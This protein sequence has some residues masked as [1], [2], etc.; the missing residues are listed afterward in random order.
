MISVGKKV[1]S[2]RFEKIKHIS[3]GGYGDVSIFFDRV[4]KNMVVIK[5]I[6]KNPSSPKMT[7]KAV[8]SEVGILSRLQNSCEESFLCYLD[9]LEDE[10]FYYILTEYLGA[11]IWIYLI[12]LIS[13]IQLISKKSLKLLRILKEDFCTCHKLG[14]VHRDI[15]PENIMVN[16]QSG[17]IKYI[18]FGA[19]CQMDSCY[20]ISPT[21]ATLE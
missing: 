9:F 11:S 10:N 6:P 15:K 14:V 8:V 21:P 18:D 5:V 1:D 7:E 13:Q 12:I 19:S 20:D 4:R 16:S 2:L 3:Q 17:E